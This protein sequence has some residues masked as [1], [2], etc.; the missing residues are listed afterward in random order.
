MALSARDTPPSPLFPSP[1]LLSPLRPPFPLCRRQTQA[2][3][4]HLCTKEPPLSAYAAHKRAFCHELC[5]HDRPPFTPL[6]KKITLSS[7]PT[8][9]PTP[10]STLS[11]TP[12]QSG[13]HL[14]R[15][16]EKETGERERERVRQIYSK[17]C[18]IETTIRWSCLHHFYKI[19]FPLFHFPFIMP[20]FSVLFFF[21]SN[22]WGLCLSS[23]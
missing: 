13:F 3:D 6:E 12:T 21:F 15:E 17:L 23:L 19:P 20:A 2:W 7:N 16:S 9:P 4:L 14:R 5:T 8:P 18:R 11:P 22:F 1:P 10:D